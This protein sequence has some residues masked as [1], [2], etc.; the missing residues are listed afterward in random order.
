MPTI[1]GLA[2]GGT[3]AGVLI[4]LALLRPAVVGANA[5]RRT[6]DVDA[7]ARQLR[8]LAQDATALLGSV[9]PPKGPGISCL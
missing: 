6:T 9:K 1:S 4:C 5:E 3:V 7:L 2:R 8:R